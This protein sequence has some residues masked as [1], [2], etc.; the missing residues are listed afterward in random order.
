VRRGAAHGIAT[1]ANA[2]LQTLVQVL[3]KQAANPATM[4]PL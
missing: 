3:E 4:A 2:L 1:P